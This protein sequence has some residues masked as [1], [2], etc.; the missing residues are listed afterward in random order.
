MNYK[1]SKK[2]AKPTPAPA[3]ENIYLGTLHAKAVEAEMQAA[4]E[5]ARVNR[6]RLAAVLFCVSLWC[7]VVVFYA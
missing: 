4:A 3:D 2:P 6:T 5:R 7:A 1:Y